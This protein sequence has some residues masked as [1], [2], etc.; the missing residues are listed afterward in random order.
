MEAKELAACSQF[1]LQA[2]IGACNQRVRGQHGVDIA[3]EDRRGPGQGN[4]WSAAPSLRAENHG[5]QLHA[6]RA[7]VHHGGKLSKPRRALPRMCSALIKGL[8][9]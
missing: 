4:S 7:M 3:L 8:N 1:Y 9:S 2:C 6:R 5:R